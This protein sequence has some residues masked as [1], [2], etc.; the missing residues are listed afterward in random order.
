MCGG[1][2]V[3]GVVGHWFFPRLVV[4]ERGGLMDLSVDLTHAPGYA[5]GVRPPVPPPCFGGGAAH[6]GEYNPYRSR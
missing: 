2:P 4:V 5:A 6:S 1:E 3:G